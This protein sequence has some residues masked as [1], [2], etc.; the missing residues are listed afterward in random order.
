MK[1]DFEELLR[2]SL[3]CLTTILVAGVIVTPYRE[4]VKLE[5]EKYENAIK[6]LDRLTAPDAPST[7]QPGMHV[8]RP[9]NL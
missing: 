6:I 9:F 2:L 3:I 5:R 1:W 7:I 8:D 4:S